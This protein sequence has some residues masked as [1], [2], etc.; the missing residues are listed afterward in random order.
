M[1]EAE[2]EDGRICK[3]L[4]EKYDNVCYVN[5]MSEYSVFKDLPYAG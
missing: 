1:V 4:I 5:G 3:I 2:L